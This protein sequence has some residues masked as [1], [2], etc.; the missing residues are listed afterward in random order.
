MRLARSSG[1]LLHPTSLPAGRIDDHAFRFVDWLAEA[2]Q[3]WWQVLP[4]GPPDEFGSPYKARSAFAGSPQLLADSNATVTGREVERF[5]AR[6]VFWIDDW[7]RFAGE[8]GVADQVRFDREWTELRRYAAERGIRLFGDMPLYVSEGSADFA[9]HA[10][11]FRA[12]IVAGVPPDYFS[13]EG[14]RWGNPLYDWRTMRATGY[15]WW[16]ERFRRTFDLVDLCRVDHFR[17]F[18]AY[19]AVPAESTTAAVGSW[20]RGPGRDLFDAA[21]AELGDI[22]IVAEDLGVITPPV[23]RLRDAL[24]FP[25]MHVL[26]FGLAGS[27]SNPHRLENH[28]EWA[29]VYTGTHDNDT[30]VG[31]ARSTGLD[32]GP[33]PNWTLITM[34]MSSRSRLA[35]VPMQD[36]LGLGSQARMNRPG[37]L[38]GNWRWRM[39]EGAL[40]PELAARL[41]SVAA[42][43]GRV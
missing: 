4:L 12:G 5:R 20:R 9:A 7:A 24:G 22:A 40:T 13:A 28:R 21:S 35:I 36:V 19:W 30:A 23:E 6:N 1:I 11:L 38:E 14:Q 33:E 15:R 10:E 42:A 26:Q 34:A 2:G 31:F 37:T 43:A 32:L 29:V 18:V 3:S 27:A 39:G 41:R 8:P 25:G 17:A 16:V